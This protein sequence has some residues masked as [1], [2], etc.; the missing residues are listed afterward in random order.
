VGGRADMGI[1]FSDE[2]SEISFSNLFSAKRWN[3]YLS[4]IKFRD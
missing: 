3:N 1:T 2:L 4:E